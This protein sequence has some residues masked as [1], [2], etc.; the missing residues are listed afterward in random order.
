MWSKRES[1]EKQLSEHAQETLYTQPMHKPPK[2]E[3]VTNSWA[4]T[5]IKSSLVKI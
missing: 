4:T 1:K 2:L 5:A 3:H